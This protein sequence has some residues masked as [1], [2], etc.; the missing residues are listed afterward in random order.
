LSPSPFFAMVDPAQIQYV[1]LQ[2]IKNAEEAIFEFHGLGTIRLK[3]RIV[4][5]QIEIAIS[6]D[7]PGISEENIPKVFNSFFTTKEN[8][9]GLGLTISY[10]VVAAHGGTLRV[11][12]KWG[13]GTTFFI[14]LPIVEKEWKRV[15]DGMERDLKGLRGIVIDDEPAMLNLLS[16]YLQNE[17]CRIETAQDVKTALG[18]VEER[19]FDFAICDMRMPEMG[20]ADFYHLIETKKPSLRSKIIFITGDIVRD[21]TLKFIESTRN[22]CMEKPF[23]LRDLK[24]VVSETLKRKDHHEIVRRTSI[25]GNQPRQGVAPNA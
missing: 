3:T 1:V 5:D 17:G 15:G 21:K 4:Q 14:T 22:P 20:G 24:R 2:M 11:E 13:T 23:N 6:D 8:E 18:M 7:G 12:S 19:D 10:G 9:M 25:R 16:E